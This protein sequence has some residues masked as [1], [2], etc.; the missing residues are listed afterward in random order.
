MCSC[1]AS[2]CTDSEYH[3]IVNV[4]L[5]HLT[6]DSDIWTTKA[7]DIRYSTLKTLGAFTLVF[8]GDQSKLP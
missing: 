4:V 8:D 5:H 3:T 6:V 7:E 1:I 2:F